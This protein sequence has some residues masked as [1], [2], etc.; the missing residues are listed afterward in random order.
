[1][2]KSRRGGLTGRV[3]HTFAGARERWHGAH[4]SG[5]NGAFGRHSG[6]GSDVS[7][8]VGASSVDYGRICRNRHKAAKNSRPTGDNVPYTAIVKTVG[9]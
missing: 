8:S 4:G 6:F 7:Q 3:E 2:C 1:M 9:T 5:S